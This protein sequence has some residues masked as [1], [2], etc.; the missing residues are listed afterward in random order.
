MDQR[1]I[2]ISNRL[3]NRNKDVLQKCGHNIDA[4]ILS[5]LYDLSANSKNAFD[6][7]AQLYD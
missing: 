4:D 3:E 6:E 1:I 5:V 7:L 2:E